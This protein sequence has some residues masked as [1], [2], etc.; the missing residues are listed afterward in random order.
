M[1]IYYCDYALGDDA[2]LGTSAGAGNAWKTIEKGI[3]GS[4]T[5]DTVYLKNSATYV[6][7]SVLTDDRSQTT[8]RFKGYG[9]SIEDTGR[10]TVQ[11][12]SAMTHMFLASSA[13]P[14]RFG[15]GSNFYNV[16]F[17]G[18]A[19]STNGVTVAANAVNSFFNCDFK[20]CTGYGATASASYFMYCNAYNNG[21]Y[22][23]YQS[24][25]A[26]TMI[27]CT[28][29][30]NTSHGV[31]HVNSTV[32]IVDC[33][34]HSNGGSGFNTANNLTNCLAYNNTAF[35]YTGAGIITNCTLVGKTGGDDVA[36]ANCFCINS[37]FAFA[38]SGKYGIDNGT[39]AGTRTFL[40]SCAVYNPSGTDIRTTSY[41]IPM[42]SGTTYTTLTG[43]P[44]VDKANGNYSLNTVAGAGLACRKTGNP[45]TLNGVDTQIPIGYWASPSYSKAPLPWNV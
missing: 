38:P 42:A 11:A 19:N 45:T 1:A 17:D 15:V 41:V 13:T 23:F 26:A 35:A 10:I 29:Y 25:S 22:G 33:I 40:E 7:S 6:I 36:G 44:F 37:I 32:I 14:N 21:T 43:D 8:R 28:A 16:I 34:A 12:T 5:G 18:N 24:S 27:G 2:N 30:S 39:T 4:A 9:T 3:S 20:G 31:Y